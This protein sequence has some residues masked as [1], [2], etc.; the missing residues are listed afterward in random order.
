[1]GESMGEA[2]LMDAVRFGLRDERDPFLR[3][4]L[5]FSQY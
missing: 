1:M 2:R 5:I 4:H 3:N